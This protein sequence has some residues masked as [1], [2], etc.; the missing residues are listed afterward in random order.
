VTM[1]MRRREAP[2]GGPVAGIVRL[3]VEALSA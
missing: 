1:V 3:D 2:A